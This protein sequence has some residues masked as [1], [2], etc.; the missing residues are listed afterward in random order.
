MKRTV[1]EILRRG[2]D[3]MLANWPLLMIRIAESVVFVFIAIAAV[4]AV[5]IPLVVSLGL[6]GAPGAAN[7]ADA[8]QMFLA[9][10]ASH[11]LIFVYILVLV[12]LVVIV[13]LG[14]HS[15]VV[16]GCARVYVDAERKAQRLPTPSRE[17]MNAFTVEAWLR[18]GRES[19]WPVF[20]IYNIAWTFASLIILVPFVVVL[21]VILLV[22]ENAAAMAITG[23]L[24]A[25]VAI[26]FIIPVAVVTGIWTQKA[27]VDCA[28]RDLGAA[29][30]LRASWTEFRSDLGRHVAVAAVMIIVTFAASMV[31]SGFSA[32]GS[33]GDRVPATYSI[34]MIPVQFSASIV[35][36]IFST[37]VGA[38]FLACFSVLA[39]ESRR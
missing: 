26:L 25:I 18:G 9:A 6:S 36:S 11:W 5:V 2:F 8:A 32:L 10:L 29:D 14:I 4:I 31:F 13:L 27:I 16:G 22:R 23:C 1:T 28:A 30:A 19:W 35:N 39:V 7:P 21:A 33:L 34:M 17:D 12:M 24:G 37:A 15:F 20:W 38:W 3:S